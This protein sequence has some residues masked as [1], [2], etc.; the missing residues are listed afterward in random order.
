MFSDLANK[1]LSNKKNRIEK[2]RRSPENESRKDNWSEKPIIQS[3]WV[4][5]NLNVGYQANMVPTSRISISATYRCFLLIFCLYQD[6]I[7][8]IQIKLSLLLCF[9]F[10]LLIFLLYQIQKKSVFNFVALYCCHPEAAILGNAKNLTHL[11]ACQFSV[12][13]DNFGRV[14]NTSRYILCVCK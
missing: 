11:D 12:D 8:K 13:S 4:L 1:N 9:D 3:N 6:Y 5:P 2:T 14:C 7:S 10:L